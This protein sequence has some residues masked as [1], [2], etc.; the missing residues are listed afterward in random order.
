MKQRFSSLDVQAI[1]QEL[2][3]SLCGLRVTNIYDLSPRIFLIRFHKPDRREQFVI[4]SGFRCHLTKFSRETAATPSAFIARLR[5]SLR[6]RR[7]TSVSQVGTDRILEFQFSDGLY[8]LFL[9]FYAG[10]NIILTDADFK[11]I[12]PLRT[13]DEGAEH[14]HVRPG[15]TYNLSLRQNVDGVPELTPE[16]VRDGL[17]NFVAR[18]KTNQPQGAG[19]KLKKTN[20]S[21]L[22]SSVSSFMFELPPPLLDHALQQ[23]GVDASMSPESVLSNDQ[24]FE[25]LMN[26]LRSAKEV[27]QSITSSTQ[28]NGYIVAKNTRHN[29]SASAQELDDSHFAYDEYH[30][31]KPCQFETSENHR[32]LEFD[33]FNHTVDQ[34]YSALEGQKLESRLHAREDG[35]KKRLE[36][37]RQ[38]HRHR[39]EGLQKV[40]ETNVRKAEAIK[41]NLERVEEATKAI[42]S[43]I[44]QGMDWVDIERLIKAEQERGN[45]TALTIKPPLKLNENAITLILQEVGDGDSEEQNKYWDAD[46]T[47]SEESSTDR[48]AEDSSQPKPSAIEVDVRL[49]LS[50][51]ANARQYYDQKK[52]ASA[53]EQRTVESSTVALKRQEHKIQ[54]DLKQGLKQEKEILRPLRK[55]F[56]FEKFLYFISS[57]G[58]LVLGGK[59]ATQNEILYSRYLK[60]GDVYVHADLQGA[61]SVII[62]NNPSTPNAPIPPSTLSQAGSFSVCGSSAWDSKAPMSAWWVHSD[63]VSK[64]AP[65]GEYLT[66]GGFMIQGKKNYLPPSQLLMGIGVLFQVS[67]ES[68]V[69]HIKDRIQDSRGNKAS[70]LSAATGDMTDEDEDF[71]DVT[72]DSKAPAKRVE[73]DT[74][75]DDDFPDVKIGPPGSEL[76]A[77]EAPRGR[78]TAPPIP[79]A[80]RVLPE[81]KARD[82]SQPN[83]SIIDSADASAKANEEQEETVHGQHDRVDGSDTDRNADRDQVDEEQPSSETTGR[84]NDEPFSR[85]PSVAPSV[86]N[87]QQK[88]N[89]PRGKR[90]KQKRAAAKYAHQ[91]EEDRKMALRLLGAQASQE[92]AQKELAE[93]KQ[94]ELEAARDKERRREQHKQA[95][96][97]GLAAEEA[98][99]LQREKESASGAVEMDGEDAVDDDEKARLES[100]GLDSFIGRPLPGDE[101]IAALPV[102]APWTALANF[103]YKVKIQPGLVKRGKAVKEIVAGWE[104]D[105]KNTK[106]IDHKSEDADRIWPGEVDL[107]RAWKDAEVVGTIPVPKMKVMMPG[108]G[109]SDSKGG[110]SGKSKG[111]PGRGG[112]G[113]KS[114]KKK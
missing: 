71:P 7:V 9:E 100:V 111:N 79:Q 15:S 107:I 19:G 99:R 6:T 77:S 72:I 18:S 56:W 36:Q 28:L 96:A 63:Q 88:P 78:T 64:T 52:V 12:T 62:M 40:Q 85:Q 59:D 114:S 31:F 20:K 38:D 35:A 102:C 60:D 43:L 104:R 94:K 32:I 33:G 41:A 1:A 83:G 44:A 42:N 82:N 75:D 24:A 81:G 49:D 14:E 73:S 93:K 86:A 106:R 65:T 108:G 5:K 46:E 34:F 39:V 29:G 74:E 53:K 13:V 30:P 50:G 69:R 103:K 2:S 80:P 8:R 58:Y 98:R 95:Q 55:Q 70:A 17:Q 97:K 105:F 61:P 11:V 76:A 66:A 10:G 112:R 90:S 45:P 91:D 113:G 47:D 37:A 110:G 67:D 57:D 48:D 87:S 89:L 92:K 16:R 3:S 54:A 27:C 84:L 25:S 4:E 109:G 21:I 51:W 22:R 23:E 101:L 68:K 26:A